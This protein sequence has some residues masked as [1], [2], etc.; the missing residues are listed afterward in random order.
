V[1][2]RLPPECRTVSGMAAGSLYRSVHRSATPCRS[3]LP[4]P[5]LLPCPALLLPLLQ[6]WEGL[7]AEADATLRTCTFGR[8]GIHLAASFITIKHV[9]VSCETAQIDMCVGGRGGWGWALL[10]FASSP[11][12]TPT[13]RQHSTHPTSQPLLP[14]PPPHPRRHT[15]MC[16]RQGSGL[17]SWTSAF[18][19]SAMERG[20]DPS[21]F[22]LMAIDLPEVQGTT[23]RA[24]GTMGE[25][26]L[27]HE[28]SSTSASARAGP[29]LW[30]GACAG[31][32]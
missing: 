27:M 19:A 15:T 13:L 4:P 18:R 5:R 25:C 17:A 7:L 11:P 6:D 32:A 1:G 28:C 20:L 23:F 24:L 10:H 29:G 8:I 9:N 22:D 14:C 16:S 26:S 12:P 2:Q 31:H 21:A 3:P 30:G